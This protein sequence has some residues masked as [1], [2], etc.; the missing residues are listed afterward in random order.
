[1]RERSRLP[2]ERDEPRLGLEV[3]RRRAASD[4]AVAGLELRPCE[5][6][7]RGLGEEDHVSGAPPS[8]NTSHVGNEPDRADGRRGMDR[9][10]VRL[11]VERHVPGDDRQPQR[12][13]RGSHALDRLLEL[14]AD[15]RLLGVPEVQ[16]VGESERLASRARDVPGRLEDGERASQE[17]VEPCDPALA[18][19]RHGETAQGRPEAKHGSVEPRPPHRSRADELVIAAIDERAAPKVGRREELEESVGDRGRIHDLPHRH[20]RPGLERQVVPRA[21]VRQQARRDLADDLVLPERAQ[22]TGLRHL[23]DRR[24]VELPAVEHR[25]DG[26]GH[27]RPDDRDHPLLALGDHD[28][29]RLHPLLAQGDAVEVD[30]DAVVGRHLGERGSDTRCTAVLERLDEPALDELDRGLDQLLAHERIADLHRRA[31]LGRLVVELLAREHRRPADPVAPR[32]RPVQEDRVA[33][34]RRLR[35]CQPVGRQQPDAHR[36]DQAVVPVGLVEHR[37]ASDRG[38]SDTVSVVADPA[39]RAGEVPVRLAEAQPV[40]QRDRPRAHGHDVAEDPA[41]ARR[42]ALERLDGRRVVVALDLERDGQPVAEIEHA[43]VLA[44]PL[45]HALAVARKALQ[46]ERR[47]LVAAVLRP[48]EREDGELEVVRLAPEERL[49]ALVLPVRE[50]EGTMERLFRDAAQGISLPVRAD[51]TRP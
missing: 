2:E 37:L 7:R 44:R 20:G 48:E 25:L 50:A 24:V 32:R 13:T 8:R 28:L 38:D 27:P 36:V 45:Q 4:L 51:L 46:E 3:E 21:L 30:V 34:R 11:V 9:A 29:P 49:D 15:L 19:E 31:L 18:V 6:D 33:R 35:A 14:P 1:M 42:R 41:D 40:E 47:V 23:A 43:R 16:A 5:R 10:A 12:A 39:D 17:G 26:L 22:L